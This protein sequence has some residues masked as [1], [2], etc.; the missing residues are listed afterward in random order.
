MVLS[1]KVREFRF[2]GSTSLIA[3]RKRLAI[4]LIKASPRKN[5]DSKGGFSNILRDNT[6]A[7]K[8]LLNTGLQL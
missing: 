2:E 3:R 7:D 6:L 8:L 5:G 1:L 4:S